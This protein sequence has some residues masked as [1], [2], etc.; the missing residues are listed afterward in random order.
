MRRRLR[1]GRRKST[2]RLL[3]NSIHGL[4]DELV[5]EVVVGISGVTFDPL[6][7]DVAVGGEVDYLLDEGDVFLAGE[8]VV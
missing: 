3:S 6:E 5:G 1:G 2:Q 8:G 4:V 7:G